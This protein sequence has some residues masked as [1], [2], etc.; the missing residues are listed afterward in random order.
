MKIRKKSEKIEKFKI[1]S[2][3]PKIVFLTLGTQKSGQNVE[4]KHFV[5][6][7]GGSLIEKKNIIS[8]IRTRDLSSLVK[9]K[10]LNNSRIL[11]L[12]PLEKHLARSSETSRRSFIE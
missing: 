11:R 9:K 3:R 10:I 2:S 1:K 6:A 12:P 4:Y 7:T 5:F 8:V